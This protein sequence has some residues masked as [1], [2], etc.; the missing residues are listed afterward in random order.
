VNV[1]VDTPVNPTVGQI[2]ER[3]YAFVIPQP[4]IGDLHATAQK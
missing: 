2:V 3:F 1:Q 4:F